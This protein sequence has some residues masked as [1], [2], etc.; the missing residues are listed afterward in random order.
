[1]KT[2]EPAQNKELHRLLSASRQTAYKADLVYSFSGGR[3]ES[4]R[5]LSTNEAAALI[6]H[7][8]GRKPT[9][10]Y[11]C[12]QKRKRLIGMSYGIGQNAE[13]VKKWCEKYGV[14]GAKKRFN[15][16]NSRELSGLIAK[17][18]KVEKHRVEKTLEIAENQAQ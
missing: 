14:G 18:A 13:F 6:L 8:K 10:S 17:F 11:D 7:L 9:E 4:S 2:I 12:E 1:M 16:Y 3:T 5:E 15:E